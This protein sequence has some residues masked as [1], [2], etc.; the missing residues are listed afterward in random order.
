MKPKTV[1]RK[2]S[3]TRK[4]STTKNMQKLM[5]YSLAPRN[6]KILGPSTPGT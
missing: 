1:K 3:A 6:M 5:P 2:V 4:K